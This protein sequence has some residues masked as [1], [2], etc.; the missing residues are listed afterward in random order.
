L[1]FTFETVGA[2]NVGTDVPPYIIAAVPVGDTKMMFEFVGPAVAI[3]HGVLQKTTFGIVVVWA[4][5]GPAVTLPRRSKRIVTGKLVSSP[6]TR[7]SLRSAKSTTRDS[8]AVSI[9]PSIFMS[10]SNEND[11]ALVIV[12]RD[13]FSQSFAR[14]FTESNRARSRL[15]LNSL[16]IF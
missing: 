2:E 1:T 15:T 8:D 12:T 5:H 14:R 13:I 4:S 6:T 7:T 3:V 16:A 10:I 11:E 9:V